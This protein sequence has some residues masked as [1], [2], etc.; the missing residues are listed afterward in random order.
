LR[1]VYPIDNHLLGDTTRKLAP[2]R[3]TIG[4]WYTKRTHEYLTYRC[5]G[6]DR[7]DR[8]E[9]DVRSSVFCWIP[10][11]VDRQY[12]S[13]SCGSNRNDVDQANTGAACRT[14]HIIAMAAINAEKIR[15]NMRRRFDRFMQRYLAK[16]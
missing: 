13:T 6:V 7:S 10:I 3:V 5:Y 1:Q 11:N 9:Q 8:L 15:C 16:V 2:S 14:G 4:I 12:V